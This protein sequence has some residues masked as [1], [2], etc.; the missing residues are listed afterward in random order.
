MH[1]S[2]KFRATRAVAG[3]LAPAGYAPASADVVS[4][5]VSL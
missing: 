5:T 1:K 4:S 2:T 3:T